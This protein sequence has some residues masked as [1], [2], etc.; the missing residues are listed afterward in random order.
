MAQTK[1]LLDSNSYFRLAKSIQ[2]LLFEIFGEA[3]YCLYVVKELEDEYSNEP[4]LQSKFPW[5]NDP[6]FKANRGKKL[7]LSKKQKKER[8]TT[9][10]F[11]RDYV[12]T[13]LPGP[14]R[15][16]CTILSYGYVLGIE[17]VTDDRDMTALADVF[18]INV[19]TTLQ[20]MKRM[21][22][23]NHINMNQVRSIASLWSYIDD[24]PKDYIKDYK[25]LFGQAPPP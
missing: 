9:F 20:L 14:S 3:C 8:Q 25:K 11:L 2:P 16:D 13:S 19:I 10:D 17:I 21:L 5:V 24:R 12:Q 23:C 22:D 4:R 1:I 6:E 15:V 18:G 7:T